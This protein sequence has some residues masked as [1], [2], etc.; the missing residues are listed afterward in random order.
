MRKY[1]ISQCGIEKYNE[2][3]NKKG[4]LRR[5]RLYWFIAI[6]SVR[7]SILHR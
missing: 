3:N 7:D 1:I 4:I 2:L 6:A 5:L